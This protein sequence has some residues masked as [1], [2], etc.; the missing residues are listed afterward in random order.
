MNAIRGFNR[1]A[2][3]VQTIRKEGRILGWSFECFRCQV[4]KKYRSDYFDDPYGAAVAS[5]ESHG[6]GPDVKAA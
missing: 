1:A 3:V 5:M 2:T 6:C 4:L